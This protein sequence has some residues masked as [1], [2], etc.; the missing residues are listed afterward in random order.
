MSIYGAKTDASKIAKFRKYSTLNYY[1][2]NAIDDLEEKNR[3]ANFFRHL[4]YIRLT[5][6]ALPSSA[7]LFGGVPVYLC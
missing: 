3:M 5:G 4:G 2:V 6:V 1:E 7:I